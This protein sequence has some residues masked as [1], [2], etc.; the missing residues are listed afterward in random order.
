MDENLKKSLDL[1]SQEVKDN[2]AKLKE[3]LKNANEE[4]A[5]EILATFEEKQKEL[6][7]KYEAKAEELDKLYKAQQDHLDNLD[8]RIQEQKH[9]RSEM[10]FKEQF[11]ETLKE[12]LVDNEM[13]KKLQEKGA[14]HNFLFKA[15]GDMSSGNITTAITNEYVPGFLEAGVNRPAKRP[16][17][18]QSLIRTAF[19]ANTRTVTWFERSTTEGG[20]ATRAEAAT[21]AQVDYDWV[22]KQEPLKFISGYTKVT[23][24]ALMDLSWLMSEINWELFTDIELALDNQLLNGDNTGT[25]LNGIIT[26]ATAFAAGT[27]AAAVDNANNQD[28][29]RV[30]INQIILANHM[31]NYIVMHPSDVA[32]MDLQKATDG[33][34]ILPPFSTNGNTMIKGL[35]VIQNT[36]ITA[37]DYLVMDST[38]ATA[39]FREGINIRIWDQN[40]DD[41]LFNRKTITANV[42]VL[43]RIKGNDTTAFV[44][45]DFTTDKAALETP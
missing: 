29:L 30:A 41:P 45:G 2:S 40:E 38:K 31:P 25:N 15:V 11:A 17:F 4:K 35:P 10:T 3:D 33:H 9:R 36:G 42:E 28:V 6:A 21:M 14:Q 22:R 27:F 8:K 12:Q 5:K 43:N 18:I 20:V 16:T 37:G 44:T 13:G 32:A 26:Q 19:L 23:N 39:Y 34:Y 7:E 1:I 24:E